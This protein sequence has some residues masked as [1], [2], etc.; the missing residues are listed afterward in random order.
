MHVQTKLMNPY[1]WTINFDDQ[2]Y[3][4]F[5]ISELLVVYGKTI[6]EMAI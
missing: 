3:Y 1:F 5:S 4:N 6:L 2:N